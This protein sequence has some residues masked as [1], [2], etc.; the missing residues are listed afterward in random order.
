VDVGRTG[1]AR[2][3]RTKAG[4]KTKVDAVA[5]LAELQ[6]LKAAGSWVEPS[7]TTLGAFLDAW[8]GA[9]DARAWTRRGYESVIRTHIKPALG[10]RPLRN[11]TKAEI[12][13]FYSDLRRAGYLKG[14]KSGQGLS[15][16]SVHNVRICLRAALNTAV[17]N[18]LMRVNPASRALEPPKSHPEMQT[19]TAEELNKFLGCLAE[20]RLFPFYRLAAFSG[21][22]RGELLGLRWSDV[23]WNLSSVSV[24][25][26]LGLDDDRDGTL[27]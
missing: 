6:T 19:W 14:K 23:K 2:D 17:E 4:F 9:L 22:R 10:L 12:R 15:E 5:A 13:A 1:E 3:Q 25:R 16:K 8:V 7:K 11:L 24:Q 20:E 27:T 26:Q 21:M 18:G